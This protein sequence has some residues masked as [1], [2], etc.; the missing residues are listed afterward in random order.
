MCVC[1]THT[2]VCMYICWY[3]CVCVVDR[4]LDIY[5][6]CSVNVIQLDREQAVTRNV[7][8]ELHFQL[9]LGVGELGQTGLIVPWRKS[10]VMML[11]KSTW[12]MFFM[13]I[14]EAVCDMIILL[15]CIIYGRNG[16][17]NCDMKMVFCDRYYVV[18]VY[19]YFVIFISVFVLSFFIII[20]FFITHRLCYVMLCMPFFHRHSPLID[21]KIVIRDVFSFSLEPN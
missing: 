7:I 5:L 8:L 15:S 17:K 19:S 16:L 2:H 3:T 21:C 13:L 18:L 10:C 11:W 1:H 9:E 4:D 20:I 12:T 6:I 14:F